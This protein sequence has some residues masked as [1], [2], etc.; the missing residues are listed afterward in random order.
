[1]VNEF[2]FPEGR[3]FAFTILDDT[4]DAT[5][6]NVKPIYDLLARLGMRTTKTVWP[7]DSAP[8]LKGHY[9][10]GATLE[11]PEYRAWIL[12]LARAGFEIAF[13]NASMTS[14]T[15]ERTIAG[16][17]AMRDLLGR[18]PRLH[19]NHGQNAENLYW[20]AARYGSGLRHLRPLA[21]LLLRGPRRYEGE[22][23]GSPYFWGDIAHETFDYVRSFAFRKVDCS[24]IPPG[25]PYLDLS[26]PWV[27]CWFNTSDA[28]TARDFVRLVTPSRI[29]RLRD[30]GGWCVI[31][32]HLGK[33]FAV[34][35]RLVP[36]VEDVLSHIATEPGWFVP[37][38]QLLDH[39]V[40]ARPPEP[41]G[42]RDRLRLEGGHLLDRLAD[43][44]PYR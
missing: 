6:E 13:H 23:D 2:R 10:R 36:Q 34:G 38:S 24:E 41:L 18:P 12:E 37:T 22:I 15:R 8:E 39:L 16:L 4:D 20:G 31:S 1:M 7:L 11:D 35:G 30:R 33:G 29:A 26:K 3:R 42:P 25:R 5:L 14:S 27:R 28:P 21:G 44:V 32:T 43:R 17:E 9:H 19:C 40:S